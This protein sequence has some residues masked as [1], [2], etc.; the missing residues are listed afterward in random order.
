MTTY[1]LGMSYSHNQA[2]CLVAD[3]R[4]VVAIQRERL[5]RVKNDG[6]ARAVGSD[7][8]ACYCLE[9]A[10]IDID[11]VANIVYNVALGDGDPVSVRR[12]PFVA[13][14]DRYPQSLL[15]E[16][17]DSRRRLI[18]HHSA[19]A[20]AGVALSGWEDAAVMVV[21]GCGLYHPSGE[22]TATTVY[23]G[24]TPAASVSLYEHA[25]FYILRDGNLHCIAKCF[26][27]PGLYGA[28]EAFERASEAVFGEGLEGC[29]KLMGLAPFGDATRYESD[30]ITPSAGEPLLWVGDPAAI[31][32]FR[33]RRAG[34]PGPIG[35][36]GRP[37]IEEDFAARVQLG[38]ERALVA[39]ALWLYKET[40]SRRLI[41]SGGVALNSVA[42]TVLLDKTPFV[43][44]FFVPAAN[45]GGIAIGCA[46]RAYMDR[47][48]GGRRTWTTP[49]HDFLGRSYSDA[50]IAAA[51]ARY[52]QSGLIDVRETTADA[53]VTEAARVLAAGR[54]VAWFQGGSEF[55]PRALGHRSIL[56]AATD[57]TMKDRLNALVKHRESFRPFAPAVTEEDAAK[58]FEVD[59]SSPYMLRV[60]D[61][62]IEYQ[63]V[64][65]AV[66][67]VD[68]TARV[69]TVSCNTQPL[70]H[71]LIV[72]VG[73]KTG[74]PVILN[75]SFNVAGE[76]IVEDPNDA[77]RCL[78]VTGID[79]L[80]IGNLWIEP[81]S[82]GAEAAELVPAVREGT[83]IVVEREDDEGSLVVQSI[84]YRVGANRGTISCHTIAPRI[85][86]PIDLELLERLVASVDARSTVAQLARHLNLSIERAAAHCDVLLAHGMIE[87]RSVEQES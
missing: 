47:P 19:H 69:Q 78:L 51:V 2:A 82:L 63:D 56:A 68:G 48:G 31:A 61:V 27:P 66:T 17:P 36:S 53:L 25:S 10:G 34:A 39:Q 85:M 23:V 64:L 84:R 87:W 16:F 45:D 62:R 50:E 40:E 70:L 6:R 5:T 20:Y 13:P 77:L 67:H 65:P 26:W 79:V 28:G 46:Y 52:A 57:P 14:S 29:G 30:V 32:E 41:M 59:G 18:P 55:G 72:A 80:C 43:E 83:Q 76:P 1:H 35:R 42:N 86:E 54:I 12:D 8:A 33:T 74:I 9:Y 4:I 75:T 37:Q 22:E 21:D 49:H 7:E 60:V 15:F 44:A 73:E 24:G 71:A 11:D 81:R 58:Y 3:G 38:M